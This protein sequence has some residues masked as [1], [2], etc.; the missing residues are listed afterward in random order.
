MSNKYTQSTMILLFIERG[1]MAWLNGPQVGKQLLRQLGWGEAAC[2]CLG[3]IKGS[4]HKIPMRA[5]ACA[6]MRLHRPVVPPRLVRTPGLPSGQA[7]G[8]VPKPYT[9]AL[10]LIWYGA[11]CDGRTCFVGTPWGP[12][13]VGQLRSQV[14]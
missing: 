7:C 1:W 5:L 2:L 11:R 12:V 14:R 10:C 6:P 9:R 4:L 3:C 8:T 13:L